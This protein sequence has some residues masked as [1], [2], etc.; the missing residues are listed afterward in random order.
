MVKKE[1]LARRLSH[2]AV[3]LIAF[4]DQSN[5]SYLPHTIGTLSRIWCWRHRAYRYRRLTIGSRI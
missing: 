4:E 3:D 5:A 1:L 2:E